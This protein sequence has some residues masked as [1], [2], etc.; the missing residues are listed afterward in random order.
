MRTIISFEGIDG[1]GKTIQMYH[2]ERT[3]QMRGMRVDTLSFPVYSSFFGR[4]VGK[5]LTAAEGVAASDV[6]GKSM[7]LWFALDRFE[8]FCE[9]AHEDVEVLLINRYVL[10][11]AVYQ[12]IRD[13]DLGKP[14]LLDFVLEL[15]HNHFNIPEADV[16]VYLDVNTED[17]EQNVLRKGY[18]E[19]VGNARDVYEAQSGI[20]ERARL[21]YL[22]YAQRLN[23]ILVIP[24]MEHGKMKSEQDIAMQIEEEL[25]R[26]GVL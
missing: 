15:E 11:N 17:A 16:H 19:Y 14:D 13:C 12:S 6:D 26:N 21:K 7:A 10:S 18:R 5:Y 20:Q 4:Q 2:L 25:I 22:E 23:N 8:A 1:S 9:D 3:L 24:C